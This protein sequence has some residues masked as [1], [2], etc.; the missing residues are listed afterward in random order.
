MKTKKKSFKNRQNTFNF[1]QLKPEKK[2][3]SNIPTVVPVK[4]PYIAVCQKK[5]EK[6]ETKQK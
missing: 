4:F 1:G 3:L 6:K 5:N 2:P